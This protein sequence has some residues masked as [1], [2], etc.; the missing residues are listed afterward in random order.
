MKAWCWFWPNHHHPPRAPPDCAGPRPGSQL[1]LPQWTSNY[2]NQNPPTIRSRKPSPGG[3]VFAFWPK[4]PHPCV[5]VNPHLPAPQPRLTQPQIG[6]LYPLK[7]PPAIRSR[8][9]SPSGSV[10]AFW[11]KSSHPCAPV[12]P[13][14]PASH[15]QL[16][17][18]HIGPYYP[19]T[20]LPA[21]RS[22]KPSPGGSVFTF[23][24]KSPHPH[25][26]VNFRLPTLQPQLTPHEIGLL[27]RSM[28]PPMLNS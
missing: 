21:I 27:Y 9:P 3:S 6:P 19:T 1:T 22:R 14:L 26:S 11:P 5:P 25:K 20:G 16:T 15:P 12:N 7:R 24:P 8:K 17:Q 4:S 28:T 13:H 18:P 10:F 2:P 23:W